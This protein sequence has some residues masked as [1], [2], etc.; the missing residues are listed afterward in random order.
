MSLML[1]V[2]VSL[3]LMLS[4]QRRRRLAQLP[5]WY[6]DDIGTVRPMTIL[7]AAVWP[8]LMCPGFKPDKMMPSSTWSKR[9]L[10]PGEVVFARAGVVGE[11]LPVITS[12]GELGWISPWLLDRHA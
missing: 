12:R 11:F 4:I 5:P 8:Y 2:D 3:D 6:S 9:K 7:K 1:V 10:E